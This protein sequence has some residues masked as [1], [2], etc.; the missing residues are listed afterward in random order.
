MFVC[1]NLKNFHEKYGCAVNLCWSVFGA[2]VG[3]TL[4]LAVHQFDGLNYSL[5]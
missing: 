2:V 1:S 3:V 5:A 4:Y